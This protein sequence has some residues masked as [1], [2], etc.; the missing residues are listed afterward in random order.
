LRPAWVTQQDLVQ[1]KNL[2]EKLIYNQ[3]KKE[4]KM[5][6]GLQGFLFSKVKKNI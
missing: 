5:G 4:R 3:R 2:T 6:G 1:R